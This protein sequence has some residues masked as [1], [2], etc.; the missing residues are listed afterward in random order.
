LLNQSLSHDFLEQGWNK[1]GLFL[2]CLFSR[3]IILVL[4]V[5][6]SYTSLRKCTFRI[7]TIWMGVGLGILFKLFFVWYGGKGIGLLVVLLMP[8]FLLYW[9]A[10]GMLYW[11]LEKRRLRMNH[12]PLG[13][14]LSIG[15]V[16]TGILVES[17][18]NPFLVRTY[19]NLFFK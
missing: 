5:L 10:Y 19:L 18:V 16:I 9:M 11:E 15:V 4:L 14:F 6:L 7:V 2:Q 3:G 8:H 1:W 13:I 17:Y 12:N